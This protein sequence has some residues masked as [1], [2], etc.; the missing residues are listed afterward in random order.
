[1]AL[2]GPRRRS[3]KTFDWKDWEIF[4]RV[5]EGGSFTRGAELANVP[6]SSASAAIARLETQ[7]GQ[8]LLDRTTRRTRVTQQGMHLYSRVAPHLAALHEIGSE[9]ASA[10]EEVSGTLRLSTPYE[11]GAQY[12]GPC[13]SELLQMHP[14]LNVEVDVNWDKPDLLKHGYDLAIVMTN[15]ALQDSSFASKRV[16]MIERAFFAAP[17]L[18]ERYG[19]PRTPHDLERWPKLA[20]SD[21]RRWDFVSHSAEGTSIAVDPRM[22]THNAEMRAQAALDGLGVVRLWPRFVRELV[23]QG[24]LVR[25]LPDYTSSPLKVFVL[26][27]ARKLMPASVRALLNLLEDRFG[28]TLG[29][30]GANSFNAPD[31][32]TAAP[33]EDLL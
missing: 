23:A 26:M 20:N 4:C 1:M 5:V 3:M 29:L 22:R 21:D 8:R 6:K 12:L 30:Q 2:A 27:P 32:R 28:V 11:I 24:K 9:A 16:L 17:S 13:V 14:A 25:V 33:E 15:S 18:I 7:L 10:S 19:L 31:G